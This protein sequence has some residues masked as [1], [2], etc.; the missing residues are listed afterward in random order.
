MADFKEFKVKLT[1]DSSDGNKQI[2]KTIST[3]S[4][5]EKTLEELNKKK[6]SPGISADEIKKLDKEIQNLNKAFKDSGN[7]ILLIDQNLEVTQGNL[8]AL[9]KEQRT[10]A[11]G[12]DEYKRAADKIA[13]FKD[14]LEGAKRT[15]I[16]FGEQLEAAPGPLGAFF[17]GLDTVKNSFLT[18]GGAI[19]AS[20]IGLLVSIIGG[21]TAAFAGNENA[22]KKLQ[23][24]FIGMQKIVGGLFRVFEPLLD[25]FIEMATTALPYVTKGIGIFYSSLVGLFTYIKEAGTGLAK[26]YQGIFTLDAKKISEG[27]DQIKN[28]F[29]TAAKAGTDAYSRFTEGTKE[30]TK[31]EKEEL[32]KRTE[33]DKKDKEDRDA[34]N[35]K[36]AADALQQE[37]DRIDAAI[38]LEKNKAKT[39][40]KLLEDLL[41]QKDDLENKGQKVSAE[42]L[43]LQEENRKKAVAEALK[44]DLDAYNQDVE[45]KR[46]AEEEKLK[47]IKD[48]VKFALD[49]RNVEL[50]RL[51]ILYGEDSEAYKKAQLDIYAARAKALEDEK[52]AILTKANM[53]D[54]DAVRLREISAEAG[55]LSNEVLANNKKEIQS[56]LDKNG[57]L[58]AARDEATNLELE[59]S[60]TTFERKMEILVEQQ[61]KLDELDKQKRDKAKADLDAGVINQTTYDTQI[62]TLDNNAVKNKKANEDAKSKIEKDRFNQQMDQAQKYADAANALADLAGKDTVAGKALGIAGALISTYKGAA[63]ALEQPF[64]FNLV[65]LATTIAT[66]LKTVR[67]I[68]AV[69][70]PTEQVPEVRI[71][72]QQGGV[73]QGPTH[74]MGG[75]TTPF[76]ELEG[77]EYVVNRASTMMFR[78]ALD[79]INALGGGQVDYQAQ[80]FAPQSVT[81][82]PPIFKTYVVAS[83]MSSQQEVDRIIKNRSKI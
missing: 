23:P 62:Q 82:E 44:T 34:R 59:A 12:T 76:G 30:L 79:R 73:L 50:E 71:R 49:E 7:K 80:G 16:S 5:Y 8:K 67:E 28:S 77:G 9:I 64:P 52:I 46:K 25:S 4:E 40:A 32:D 26:I 20:G 83:E 69:Q 75:I 58:Q 63:Q 57:A 11:A 22:M 17:R 13:D 39:D 70:I 27:V 18:L 38:E 61:S 60:G 78:P 66:G 74:A 19:K 43:K 48:N 68:T 2:E 1:V 15:Q 55:K 47:I 54:A 45:N 10:F 6:A 81:S 37:K 51:K 72:K 21:I 42:K 35:K 36:S 56:Q 31:T 41:K 53:T 33:Q 29:Q 3:L 65:A 24:L 14:K